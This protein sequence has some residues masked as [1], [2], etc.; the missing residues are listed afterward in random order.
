MGIYAVTSSDSTHSSFANYCSP[1]DSV[2]GVHIKACLGNIFSTNFLED[3]DKAEMTRESLQ[4]QF[5]VVKNETTQMP[6][7]QWGDLRITQEP[8]GIF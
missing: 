5:E 8:I 3:S 2:N 6:V 4:Q 7:M 1:N